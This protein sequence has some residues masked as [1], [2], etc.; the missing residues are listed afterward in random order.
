VARVGRAA[1]RGAH[2]HPWEPAV[3]PK[4]TRRD[5]ATSTGNAAHGGSVGG[6][7]QRPVA[8]GRVNPGRRDER[9]MALRSVAE[10]EAR[11]R[12]NERRRRAWR[13]RRL[14]SCS[15]AALPG[16]RVASGA[17]GA[18]RF[19]DQQRLASYRG[20]GWR[21]EQRRQELPARLRL[22]TVNER[23][24]QRESETREMGGAL[25]CPRQGERG[26]VAV[27]QA[28]RASEVASSGECQ[29]TRHCSLC[30]STL[31]IKFQISNSTSNILLKPI[32]RA[33]VTPKLRR[34]S[35]N[36]INKSCR[37]TYQLQLLLNLQSLIRPS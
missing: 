26:E 19:A 6:A 14:G 8:P 9:T 35:K 18:A 25:G 29:A 33:S 5:R 31:F 2:A 37:S 32:L 20:E 23:S 12:R 21:R 11:M 36:S 10:E 15:S 30:T 17:M 3:R 24:R 4:A 34:V 7:S 13:R 27:M 22:S 1:P 28:A 16:A